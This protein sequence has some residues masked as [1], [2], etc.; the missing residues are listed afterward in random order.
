MDDNCDR[1]GAD[2]VSFL[3]SLIR[4]LDQTRLAE[5][6]DR[7]D[8]PD[9]LADLERASRDLDIRVAALGC[10]PVSIQQRALDEAN[11]V[12]G[13]PF[14]EGVIDVLLTPSTTSTTTTEVF[15]TTEPT[16]IETIVDEATTTSSSEVTTTSG[17]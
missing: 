17:G 5:F 8:W 7:G 2:T 6:R 12:P 16:P 1:V 13:G 11:L 9:D 3:N 15:E 4:V 14:S 10:D